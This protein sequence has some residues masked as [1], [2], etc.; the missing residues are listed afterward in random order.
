MPKRSN[1]FQRLVKRI[2]DQL[3]PAGAKVTESASLPDY[4]EAA[5]PEIDV[6][7]EFEV[8]GAARPMRIAIECRDHARRAD[9]TWIDGII[10]KY[11]DVEVDRIIAVSRSEFTS[12]A[13]KK[14]KQGKIELRTLRDAL[15]TDWPKELMLI[16]VGQ[17]EYH[18]EIGFVKFD[19]R[20]PWPD[21][22]EPLAVRIGQRWIDQNEFKLWL[23]QQIVERFSA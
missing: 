16:A 7:I 23:S 2:Y 14:A 19:A 11:R 4:G 15:E 20:P 3:A 1:D 5:G 22:S 12:G 17:V 21:T 6:L 13:R 9:K 8:A 18:P 10:G